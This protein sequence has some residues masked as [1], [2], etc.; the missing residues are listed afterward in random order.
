MNRLDYQ[1][2]AALK[3]TKLILTSGLMVVANEDYGWKQ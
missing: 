3:N 2:P 1:A